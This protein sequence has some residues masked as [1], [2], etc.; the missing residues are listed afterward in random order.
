M[1]EAKK[2]NESNSEIDYSK[3]SSKNNEKSKEKS[4][5]NRSQKIKPESIKKKKLKRK[6]TKSE[7]K[8]SKKISELKKE[9]DE[10]NNQLNDYIDTLQRLQAQFENYKKRTIKEKDKLVSIA[11]KDLIREL[12]PLLDDFERAINS[13]KNGNE[14]QTIIEGL[15]IINNQF[16]QVLNKKNLKEIYP[17]GE[18]FDPRYH[19]A[20]MQI[21]SDKHEEGTV[22]EVLQKGYLLNDILL[23]PATV[24]VSKKSDKS[25]E[26]IKLNLTMQ[27]FY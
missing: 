11:N 8:L 10:K 27:K 15:N 1:S 6:K 9:I 7:I 2:Q 17:E 19:E 20:V 3:V 21:E 22:L 14:V 18:I 26:K 5:K 13:Y 25:W 4:S 12:L 23:R 16:N 24:K